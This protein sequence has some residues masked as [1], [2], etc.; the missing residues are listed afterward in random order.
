MNT[1]NFQ[2]MRS[3]L[4]VPA[5][6]LKLLESASR[7]NSDVLLLDL[8]DSVQPE[9]NKAKAR[10]N[11]LEWVQSGKFGNRIIFPRV[12]DRESGHLLKDVHQLTISGIHGFVYPKAHKGEDIYFIDKLLETIE[13]EKGIEIGTFK[14]IALIETTAAIMN[15]NEICAASKRLVAVAYGCED[16]VSDLGG[17]HDAEGRSLFTPRALIAMAAKSHGIVPID[18]VHINVHDMSDLEEN[19]RLAK[20]LGYEGMLILNPK[21]IPLAHQYFTPSEDEVNDAKETL[22]LAAEAR[23]EGK[24]VAIKNGKFIGPPMILAAEKT[25]KKYQSIIKFEEW[26]SR[27]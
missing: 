24:G 12:N 23:S 17:I 10:S 6:D 27:N 7:R 18:T 19:L 21:E 22:R 8:E 15:I 9:S 4:F 5:H 20:V 11:I 2:T 14:I 1:P 25:I 13:Y 26:Q 3:L 16:F